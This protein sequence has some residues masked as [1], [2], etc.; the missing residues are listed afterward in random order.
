MSSSSNSSGA[1]RPIKFIEHIKDLIDDSTS[2]S[3]KMERAKMVEHHMQQWKK[4]NP[5][6]WEKL[7]AGARNPCD[8]DKHD[9]KDTED[10]VESLAET[11][12]VHWND[13][14]S[15]RLTRCRG[16]EN[17]R[18]VSPVLKGHRHGV[19]EKIAVVKKVMCFGSVTPE[20]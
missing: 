13:D 5:Q 8:N 16:K 18:P 6:K 17:R 12:H 3:E 7:D 4:N 9:R 11:L 19:T 2:R 14:S 1:H 20:E 15:T 10:K